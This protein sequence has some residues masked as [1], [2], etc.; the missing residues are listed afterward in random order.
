[1]GTAFSGK[2]T[3]V[4]ASIP[5]SKPRTDSAN[6][7]AHALGAL[8]GSKPSWVISLVG[9]LLVLACLWP[10]QMATNMFRETIVSGSVE[11]EDPVAPVQQES[12][13]FDT[14]IAEEIGTHGDSTSDLGER[15]APLGPAIETPRAPVLNVIGTASALG[16]KQIAIKR[17]MLDVGAA[18]PDRELSDVVETTGSSEHAGG[19]RGAVDRLTIEI[20]ASLR[21]EN[22]LVVW[23]FDATPSM[24]A[25][26][27]AIADRFENIYRQLGKLGVADHGALKTAVATFGR[28]VEYLTR[29][30]VDDVAAIQK[31]IHNIK[32]DG[33]PDKDSVE[34]VFGACLNAADRFRSYRTGKG[35]KDRRR[36]MIVAVTDER[37]SDFSRVEDAIAKLRKLGMRVYCVGDD[38][39][40]GREKHFFPHIWRDGY[41]GLAYTLRGP[42]TARLESVQLPFWGQGDYGEITSGFGP[43]ALCR[44]C[45][46]TGGLFLISEEL[47]GPKFD[48]A[49]LR[50][51]LPDY[52]PMREY[53]MERTRNPAKA[54]LVQAAYVSSQEGSAIGRIPRPQMQFRADNDNTFRQQITQAQK[55][56]AELD[57]H[58]TELFNLLEAGEKGRTQLDTPRW[59]AAFD[60]ALGRVLALRARA[61]GYNVMLAEMKTQPRQFQ[62]PG[63]NTWRIVPASEDHAPPRSQK[64]AKRARE[65]LKGVIEEHRGTQWE[66][67]AREELS[68]PM[69][70]DWRELHID[71]PPPAP[72]HPPRN[73]IRLEEDRQRDMMRRQMEQER[74]EHPP[75]KE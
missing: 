34:N 20:E 21:Q 37:G 47:P 58:L 24:R 5:V 6:E 41:H 59:R 49:V 27:E 54:A 45:A 71:Y 63:D 14:A 3:E 17:P 48:P 39:V 22:T 33:D 2:A 64:F 32:D 69:A 75:V 38:A 67:L 18:T 10:I 42:E 36:V 40:F 28:T 43:Y 60:L 30:P 51:Y 19:I 68:A 53:E 56:L 74:E 70:W 13:R 16:T 62:T 25:R 31:A 29:K 8:A 11:D 65:L 15:V 72:P 44:L 7:P 55:P 50:N 12:L 46:E 66:L 35:N 9:H 57:Y 52:R 26:R 1:V 4:S 61:M 23:L 73:G